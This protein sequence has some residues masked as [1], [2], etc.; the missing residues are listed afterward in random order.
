MGRDVVEQLISGLGF[1]VTASHAGGGTRSVLVTSRDPAG[2]KFLVTARDQDSDG[3]EPAAK[4]ARSGGSSETKTS[5]TSDAASYPHFSAASL[6]RFYSSHA[7]RQGIAVLSFEVEAGGVEKIRARY[8]SAH[9]KLLVGD[10]KV[11]TYTSGAH[12]LE[13]F[14]YY[15]GECK[16]SDAD[17]GTII[18][19]IGGGGG[20]G[21]SSS[22]V[23]ADTYGPPSPRAWPIPGMKEEKA[24]FESTSFPAYSDHWVSNVVSREG[25]LQ[26]LEDTLGFTPKVDFNAG[27]VAAGEAQIESTVTGNTSGFETKDKAVALVN[28]S[29]VYLPINNALSP[30]GHVSFFLEEIGQ[31]IQHVASR[32]PDLIAFI[33]RVNAMRKMTGRGFSFLRIPRSYYGR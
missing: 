6:E 11:K 19:F 9:P 12:I 10:G 22:S 25:F 31:G 16:T 17:P 20:G 26:T 30:V 29:Q 27:V 1:R 5:S 28:Q 21:G 4:K 3:M 13:V 7:G 14:A 33:A 32:V 23:S 15:K 18:R 8:A 2:A 24:E